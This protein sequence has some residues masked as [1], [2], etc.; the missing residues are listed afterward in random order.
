MANAKKLWEKGQTKQKTT[1]AASSGPAAS[2]VNNI[3]KNTQTAAAGQQ[4]VSQSA[5]DQMLADVQKSPYATVSEVIRA[6]QKPVTAQPVQQNKIT[7]GRESTTPLQKQTGSASI[8]DRLAKMAQVSR[9]G[10]DSTANKPLPTMT[11]GG[12]LAGITTQVRPA[13]SDTV[14]KLNSLAAD[15]R[16]NENDLINMNRRLSVLKAKANRGDASAVDSY[17]QLADRYNQKFESYVANIG[18]YNTL[19]QG[20]YRDSAVRQNYAQREYQEYRRQ[21]RDA[22]VRQAYQQRRLEEE[23]SAPRQI[24]IG[25]EGTRTI[26]HTPTRAEQAVG[27]ALSY[28][29]SG[30]AQAGGLIAKDLF[31]EDGG[32]GHSATENVFNVG[33]STEVAAA[34]RAWDKV[35]AGG[36]DWADGLMKA[37]HELDERGEIQVKL[38]KQG[39]GTVGQALVDLGVVAIQMAGDIGLAVATGGSMLVPMGLRSYGNGYLTAEQMGYSGG[40]AELYGLGVAAVEVLSE[41]MFSVFSIAERYAKGVVKQEMSERVINA[42]VTRMAKSTTGLTALNRLMT[43]LFSAGSEGLEEVMAGIME[44][45]IRKATLDHSINVKQEIDWENALYEGLIGGILGG[46]GGAV[47][48]R[49]TRA[50]YWKYY[51]QGINENIERFEEAARKYGIE[52]KEAQQAAKAVWDGGIRKMNEVA[53]TIDGRPVTYHQLAAMEEAR[54]YGRTDA[55]GNALQGPTLAN[56]LNPESLGRY[57]DQQEAARQQEVEARRLEE[58]NRNAR[59]NNENAR[60][61]NENV[62]TDNRTQAVGPADHGGETVRLDTARSA[63]T[64]AQA[65]QG[66]ADLSGIPESDLT[67]EEKDE[68]A[69][70]SGAVEDLGQ[71][72]GLAQ[73]MGAPLARAGQG[74]EFSAAQKT[75]QA[76][77][78]GTAANVARPGNGDI[79][80]RVNDLAG[81]LQSKGLQSV[82]RIK[83][84]PRMDGMRVGDVIFINE[85]LS[86]AAAEAATMG[87]EVVHFAGDYD[88]Q[89]INDLIAVM[90]RQGR[91]IGGLVETKREIYRKQFAEM[92][93]AWDEEQ[94]NQ[95]YFEEEV[96]AD[97]IGEICR[98]DSETLDRIAA[99]EP[100]LIRRI[101]N[102]LRNMLARITGNQQAVYE[103][104]IDR[105]NAALEKAGQNENAV[106]TDDGVRYY[107][108]DEFGREFDEWFENTT[109]EEKQVDGGYFK[110]GTTSEPLRSIG[111]REGTIY[112]RKSKIGDTIEDHPEMTRDV[113]RQ[114]PEIL[115]DPVVVMRSLTR[116]RDSIVI[117][118]D[119]VKAS[120]NEYVIAAVWLTPT[121]SGRMEAEFSVISSSY[122]KK[123][124]GLQHLI[125]D[126]EILYFSQDKKR[127]D[128]WLMSLRVQFPSD[129][130]VY[131]PIG[132]IT[133]GAD[134]VNIS[135]KIIGFE[136]AGNLGGAGIANGT[137]RF[138]LA[139][140]TQ[141]QDA[142]EADLQATLRQL[143]DQMTKLTEMLSERTGEAPAV[144]AETEAA[145]EIDSGGSVLSKGQQEYFKDSK[146]RDEEGRLLILFRGGNGET[147]FNGRGEGFA[148]NRNSIYL[149]DSKEVARAYS[150]NVQTF[151]ANLTHPL[152]LDA[153]G[154]SYTDIPIPE[155][156]PQSLKDYFYDTADA[157]NLPVYAEEHGYDGVIIRNVREGKGGGPMTEVIALRSN[158]VKN[159]GNENPTS[160][161]DVR[162]SLNDT[163]ETKGNLVALHNLS[164]EKLGKALD[165]GGFPMPSI[166]VTKANI[167]HTNFGKITLVMDRRTVDPKANRKNEVYSADAWTPT[168]PQTEYEADDKVEHRL[169]RKYLDL[170]K[171]YGRELVD[172]LHTYGVNLKYELDRNGGLAGILERERNNKRMKQVYMLDTGIDLPEPTIKE[173]VTRMKEGDIAHNEYFVDAL[174]EDVLREMAP[175]DGEKVGDARRRWWTD[176]GE[177]MERIYEEYLRQ[178]EFAFSEEEIANVL[179]WMTKSEYIRHAVNARNYLLR[180]PETVTEEPDYTARDEAIAKVDQAAYEEWLENLFAGA[181]KSSGIYNNKDI[182]T[183]SGNRRSF[184]ATHFP[185]TLENIVKAMATQND[186]NSKN[187]GSFYGVKTLRAGTAVTFR[188]IPEMH[189]LEDRLQHLTEEEAEQLNKALQDRLLEVMN[190]IDGR[191]TYGSAEDNVF[192]RLDS[193]GYIMEEIAETGSWPAEKVQ[194]VFGKYSYDLTPEMGQEVSDLLTDIQQM[195]V[196]IFEA[197]PKRVVRFDEV[198]A[199]IVPDSTD[200]AL[201]DRLHEAGV[202][203]VRT[204]EDGNDASRLA[205]V[206]AVPNVRF[207]LNDDP[208]L[209]RARQQAEY[210]KQ[211]ALK[212]SNVKDVDKLTR[213]LMR[214][215]GSRA[216]RSE[217]SGRMRELEE[218][219][220]SGGS[221]AEARATARQMAEDMLNKAAV[222]ED[223][224]DSEYH[225]AFRRYFRTNSISV[226]EE[227][228][229]GWPDGWG[230]FRKR[231]FGR[232]N[233]KND[234]MDVTKIYREASQQ[235]PDLLPSDEVVMRAQDQLETIAEVLDNLEPNMVNPYGSGPEFDAA[236]DSL[237]EDIISS[238]TRT[239]EAKPKEDTRLQRTEAETEELRQ[240][241]GIE[242]ET[243]EEMTPAEMTVK[244]L[245]AAAVK[246]KAAERTM[247]RTIR[248]MKL[249][250]KEQELVNALLKG[251]LTLDE[252]RYTRYESPVDKQAV[253]AV[254]QARQAYRD[255]QAPVEEYNRQ[256]REG[257][258]EEARTLTENSF[259]WKSPN[260]EILLDRETPRR[261]FYGITKSAAE[262]E[263]L[264]ST[265]VDP[266]REHEAQKNR[267]IKRYHERIE[268]LKIDKKK[269]SGNKVSEAYAVQYIG[270]LE[271]IRDWLEQ[272]PE[273][274]T[275]GGL[276]YAEAKTLLADFW[277]QNPNLD[278]EHV[279]E[280][281]EEFR[282]IYDELFAMINEAR[283]RNGYRP[284]DYRKGYFPH[285]TSKSADTI[286]QALSNGLGFGVEVTELPTDIAGLTYLFKP[287]IQWSG[288]MLARTG[289]ETDYNVLEGWDRYIPA[290]AN[291]IYHTDDIQRWRALERTLRYKHGTTGVREKLAAIRDN[292][293]MTEEERDE[294]Y[295]KL[296]DESGK[297]D[298]THLGA[299]VQ[300]IGEY[301][302][303]LAGKR[304][305][306][307][308]IVEAKLSRKFYS[309][310]QW[311]ENRVAAN[312]LAGNISSAMTNFIPLFQAMGS[313]RSSSMLRALGEYAL[314]QVHNREQAAAWRNNSNFLVNRKGYDPLYNNAF[315]KVKNA[316]FVPFNIVDD[317]TS[318]VIVRAR[319]Y[320]ELKNGASP[321]EAMALADVFAGEVMA[322]RTVGE[323]P[324]I[325]NSKTL[326]VLTMFQVEVNNDMSHF[327]KDLPK[328]AKRKGSAAWLALLRSMIRYCIAVFLYND[329]FEAIWG[330]RVAFDPLS[331]VEDVVADL[332][333]KELPN[334]F[335]L[336][337]EWMRTK[338]APDWD[339][340]FNSNKGEQPI[341]ELFADIKAWGE[342]VPFLSGMMGGGRYPVFAFLPNFGELGS[343]VETI[344]DLAVTHENAPE[345]DWQQLYKRN[346]NLL[347]YMAPPAFGGQIRRTVEGI[348]AARKEGSY[349][350]NKEGERKLQYPILTTYDKWKAYVFGKS[351][352]KGGREWTESGFDTL[353]TTETQAYLDLVAGGS[354]PQFIYDIIQDLGGDGRTGVEKAYALAASNLKNEERVRLLDLFV[355]ESQSEKFAAMMTEGGLTFRQCAEVYDKY[356]ELSKMGELK[357]AD[358][359]YVYKKAYLATQFAAWIDGEGYTEEQK[360]VITGQYK[361]WNKVPAEANSYEHLTALGLSTDHAVALSNDWAELEPLPGEDDVTWLQKVGYAATG[362]GYL[363]SYERHMAIRNLQSTKEDSNGLT[364]QDKYQQYIVDYDISA[365]VYYYYVQA[366]NGM[367]GDDLDGDGINDANTLIDKKLAVIDRLPLQPGQKTA[368][369]L[370][371]KGSCKDTTIYKRAPW[372]H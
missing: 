371:D 324:V 33:K 169:Y 251:A 114:V 300:W 146:A 253:Q 272:L 81:R 259:D 340:V 82:E 250:P 201:I 287:G 42:V 50:T 130:P 19:Y 83:A 96:A 77:T 345:Y 163:V 243:S 86:G 32:Q 247:Q 173:T 196:N 99:E 65:P 187:S 244:E 319:Y 304:Y 303:Y 1:P 292:K 151:Y 342:N 110:V 138:S 194:R 372:L 261:V 7:A 34:A 355:S 364:K 150:A 299:F 180:G 239:E 335:E 226:P 16:S 161:P 183:P 159:V 209:E 166:A 241:L 132:N 85:R 321:A 21:N 334:G 18:I 176:H 317:L 13:A 137:T 64:R 235:W 179:N 322:D 329:L 308:R 154:R 25:K 312:M 245:Q 63:Q 339:N 188:S 88:A 14:R 269:R 48:L 356:H 6:G 338:E 73:R 229:R 275:R 195:P 24:D 330:R 56:S 30:F 353:S 290:V 158:Q 75:S 4:R 264:I 58:E 185:V 346:R 133:Y 36:R 357:N 181:E 22:G 5:V 80:R 23:L 301:T 45:V 273:G 139:D 122:T 237:A 71:Y 107:I 343:G 327:F 31:R 208:E 309:R 285:F 67:Q 43:L 347:A 277:D 87:H 231:Y 60:S 289:N 191:R 318:E 344:W 46:L 211:L 203:D 204:Y 263:A 262:A 294:E 311:L 113:L 186:G 314:G 363:S 89:L 120:N 15:I 52:S 59:I 125:K 95:A 274:E 135:G 149:T 221:E 102:A 144:A 248:R 281:V 105:L 53:G 157:D 182:F 265:Y 93:Q 78:G 109:L 288:H 66:V 254:Y 258:N 278:Q 28:Y 92:G 124:A 215:Y 369:A 47:D 168:F 142:A 349:T 121:V 368:L 320:D 370:F 141:Q 193:I 126:S 358:D 11:A 41:K 306:V 360:E 143:T 227:V 17:N 91:D 123:E 205:E 119:K 8:K 293:D 210:W 35:K 148:Y 296:L 111:V 44:P 268:K 69:Y 192:I 223:A 246:A 332:T 199:A 350:V 177:E 167:P 12:A 74:G 118:S 39:L 325:F 218:F 236:V 280:C 3:V 337:A 242:P 252:M 116:P 200:Q 291:I 128:T 298:V 165:L 217:M 197:K 94:M 359:S 160:N 61:D 238:L 354:D 219:L 284:I 84:D 108:R 156:A 51:K 112:W 9:I 97:F 153:E 351:S 302:N 76:P 90:R 104:A 38:A 279:H 190:K 207:S 134:G 174:G 366:T 348:L 367:T 175:R 230:R 271:F 276:T 297:A 286:V 249:T 70:G 129:Q 27:G 106:R 40:E 255:A 171:Q 178:P 295:S 233:L 326:K 131:G 26:E 365:E 270:E 305:L 2:A 307:D 240:E 361:F 127:T 310:V 29:G 62:I 212:N 336:I 164:A 331:M 145:E 256:H 20:E 147:V 189:A 328:D 140:T 198:R 234:G 213:D 152:I 162:F 155:D 341:S 333:G 224:A 315:G 10:K 202:E 68:L 362:A 98:A 228:K 222:P 79:T 54:A 316:L 220:R 323:L 136:D 103:Q 214:G 232:L 206:N 170:E 216:S 266:I 184:A 100:G 313:V 55:E 282:A 283:V 225:A 172:E 352:T 37:G 260:K 115:E 101:I 117:L 49:N 257:L 72:T 57:L 267:M